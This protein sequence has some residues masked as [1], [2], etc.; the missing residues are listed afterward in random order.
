[1]L[2][3]LGSE[4]SGGEFSVVF[5]FATFLFFICTFATL[6]SVREEPLISSSS[7][8]SSTRENGDTDTYNNDDDNPE[9]ETDE[10]RPLLPIR[11]NNSKS[12][13]TLSRPVRSTASKYF[14][15]LNSQEGFVE[16]DPGTGKHI[17]HD[18]VER[19]TENIL[20]RT[21][22]QSHQIAA[23]S[24]SNADPS[25]PTPV[26]AQAFEAELKQKAKLVKLGN[27][28]SFFFHLINSIL[29]LR[30][31]ETSCI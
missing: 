16:I 30:F 5:Y 1:M 3:D 2:F 21:L 18:H 27:I 12:Y 11:R 6:T 8:S 9:I 28:N 19:T 20:L 13:S 25:N 4:Y 23:A 7:S 29:F 26:P 24:M 31:D 22:E 10:E 14:T 17:P 15:D